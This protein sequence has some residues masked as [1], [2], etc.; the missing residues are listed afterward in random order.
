MK[1][2]LSSLLILTMLVC[3][4]SVVSFAADNEIYVNGT[5][6]NGTLKQALE[7]ASTTQKTLIE[8]KGNT[9][10]S[11]A[12]N[13]PANTDIELDLG[14][15]KVTATKTVYP[16]GI[17]LIKNGTYEDSGNAYGISLAGYEGAHLILDD[18]TINST[19]SS[20]AITLGDNNTFTATVDFYPGTVINTTCNVIYDCGDLTTVNIYGGTYTSSSTNPNGRILKGDAT[21]NIYGGTFKNSAVASPSQSN[22][23]N[24]LN[25]NRSKIYGGTFP[26]SPAS[27]ITSSDC[28]VSQNGNMYTVTPKNAVFNVEDKD[29]TTSWLGALKAVEDDG[30][31]KLTDDVTLDYTLK[32]QYTDKTFT[33]DLNGN[34]LTNTAQTS[35]GNSSA[36]FHLADNSDVTIVNGVVVSDSTTAENAIMQGTTW[37]DD[38]HTSTLTLGGDGEKLSITASPKTNLIASD[39]INGKIVVN[40]GVSLVIPADSTAT[41]N[42]YAMGTVEING[43][44]FKNNGNGSLDSGFIN[45]LKFTGNVSLAEIKGGTFNDNIEVECTHSKVKITGGK[46]YGDAFNDTASGNKVYDY[47]N[48][49]SSGYYANEY[50]GYVKVETTSNKETVTNAVANTSYDDGKG[51]NTV[52]ERFFK[53]ID[54]LDYAV[55]GFEIKAGEY[56]WDIPLTNVYSKVLVNGKNYSAGDSYVVTAAIGDVPNDY[57]G[58]F[59]V[60]AYAIDFEGN[61]V[62]LN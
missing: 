56:T 25:V 58:G 31:I 50:D 39:A 19:C 53:M 33:F 8:L 60:S 7:S 17:L 11:E 4:F 43:G 38:T 57:D 49:A 47:Q 54:T 48:F 30:T 42:I 23:F 22:A 61:K 13:I 35:G 28:E 45:N 16:R 37:G 29:L 52:T 3:S 27:N 32:V 12:V 55:V 1:K 34:T 2:L 15:Y 44:I 59:E 26:F 5:L 18:M 40:D 62:P 46:F 10:I 20:G 41:N 6:Y 21:F 51:A 36:I 9:T 24:S 14:G